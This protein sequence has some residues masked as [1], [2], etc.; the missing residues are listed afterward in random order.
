MN[1]RETKYV[2]VTGVK[3]N[4]KLSIYLMYLSIIRFCRKLTWKK[5]STKRIPF[6]T[7]IPK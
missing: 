5:L 7:Y 1:C 2:E 3:L 6:L 4:T